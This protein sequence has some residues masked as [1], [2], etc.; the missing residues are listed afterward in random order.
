MNS[1]I[2]YVGASA[3]ILMGLAIGQRRDVGEAW[4]ISGVALMIV[5]MSVGLK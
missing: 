2:L 1:D 5:A 3:M 4:M